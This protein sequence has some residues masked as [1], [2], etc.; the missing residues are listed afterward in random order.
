MSIAQELP[1]HVNIYPSLLFVP[2]G[3]KSSMIRSVGTKEEKA[4]LSRLQEAVF[5]EFSTRSKI[6]LKLLETF[7]GTDRPCIPVPIFQQ[8]HLYPNLLKAEMFLFNQVSPYQRIS[9][10]SQY[11]Y[12]KIWGRLTTDQLINHVNAVVSVYLFCAKV[13]SH[14][15]RYWLSSIE[16]AYENHPFIQL[17]RSKKNIVE[18]VEIMNKS[19]LL[20]VL[21]YPEDISYWRHRV[22]IVMRPY[23]AIPS[24]WRWKMCNHEKELLPQPASNTIKCICHECDFSVTYDIDEHDVALP[25]EVNLFQATKRIATIERQ[26]NDIA[27][28]SENV[29]KNIQKLQEFKY[30][31]AEHRVIIE[32]ILDLQDTLPKKL[33]MPSHPLIHCYEEIHQVSLPESMNE[34]MLLWMSNVQIS[35]ISIFKKIEEWQSMMHSDISEE[36]KR[37]HIHLT[38][39]AEENRARPDD[40]IVQMKNYKITREKAEIIVLFL[41]KQD[42]EIPLHI[43]VQ[44]LKGE[45]TNKLRSLHFHEEELFGLLDCWPEKYITKAIFQ[46]EKESY[47]TKQNKGYK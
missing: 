42:R 15:K 4:Q 17:A 3:D 6:E 16:K 26:F 45:A 12:K 24:K 8:K 23:R 25:K 2:V 32:A 39:L 7:L 1:D 41:E 22:E 30:F 13:S 11:F 18:A 38:Q 5:H 20:A 44:V 31:L 36:L 33:E 28:Q 43:L 47:I 46:L 21:K 37:V 40:I 14:E 27:S 10:E 19:S 35:D 34:S 29:T 9:I